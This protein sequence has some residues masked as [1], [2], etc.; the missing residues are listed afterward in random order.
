MVIRLFVL[1]LLSW[2]TAHPALAASFSASVDRTR[3]SE[4][5]TLT[6]SLR[7]EAQVLFQKPDFQPLEQDFRILNEQRAQR[8]VVSNGQRESYTEC[9]LTLLPLRTG[10]LTIPALTFDGQTTTAIRVRVSA[11]PAAV[12]QQQQEDFFFVTEVT[13]A[14]QQY[15]QSQLLY[16]ER[17]YY[18]Y[19]HDSAALSD[20]KVTDARVLPADDVRRYNTVIEGRRFGVY[21]RRF[22]IFPEV[23]GEL[24]IPGQ[25]FTARMI[26][27]YDRW[28]RGQQVSVVSKPLRLNVKPIPAEYPAA[29]WLPVRNLQAEDFY[30]TDPANWVAGEAV[31]H[32]LTLQADGLPGAQLPAIALPE[33]PGLRYY[34]DKNSS[35]DQMTEQGVV[36]QASQTVAMVAMQGGEL[37]MPEIRIPWWNTEL[38]RLEYAVLPARTLQVKG[39]SAAPAAAAK[40]ASPAPTAS[41]PATA[42][43]IPAAAAWLLGLGVALLLSLGLNLWQWR[44]ARGLPLPGTPETLAPSRNAQWNALNQACNSNQPAAIRTALL[45]WVNAGGMGPV[46]NPIHNLGE[47]SRRLNDP[48]LQNELAALDAHLFSN[49][50][51]SAFNGQNL[52]TLLKSGQFRLQSVSERSAGLYPSG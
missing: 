43:E 49:Q 20:L 33:I 44:R 13:P 37:V 12:K 9:L 31:V 16:T 46:N 25:R 29:P 1:V 3:I 27:A 26:N 7:Y 40:P 6:L 10:E 4:Q 17:L 22:L 19:E 39:N 34:P 45:A 5:E 41:M 28:S 38:D 36:G 2:L 23:S 47:L 51:N 18:R 11:T 32:S 21:E 15:V 30:S 50:P 8:M 42:T 35:D 24:V 52:K 48:R 14:D